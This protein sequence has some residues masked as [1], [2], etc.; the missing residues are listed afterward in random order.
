M[1]ALL[2]VNIVATIVLFFSAFFLNSLAN[3]YEYTTMFYEDET[4]RY[5]LFSPITSRLFITINNR[6]IL[7][8]EIKDYA[9]NTN[10]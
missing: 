5:L 2:Y 4:G 9:R 1:D 10:I 7:N 8:F 6:Y 3:N